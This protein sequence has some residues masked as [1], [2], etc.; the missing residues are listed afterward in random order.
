MSLAVREMVTT[1]ATF[2]VL[3]LTEDRSGR[4]AGT[5]SR[6]LHQVHVLGPSPSFTPPARKVPP[7]Y[8][9]AEREDM[10]SR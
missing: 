1:G 10:D 2:L 6:W 3:G 4:R 9:P 8:R 5:G 7:P